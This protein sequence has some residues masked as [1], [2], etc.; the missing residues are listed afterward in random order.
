MFIEQAYKGKN[1]FW[2]YLIGSLV[3]GGTAII[4]Q[5][6]FMFAIAIKVGFD[7]NGI[8]DTAN[9]SKLQ[10]L[11]SPILCVF[12]ILTLHCYYC[13]QVLRLVFVRCFWLLN[14]FIIKSL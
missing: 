2:R 8:W 9:L 13:C 14:I 1:E 6:L 11:P 7:D 4:G 12:L 3:I 10:T 5:L